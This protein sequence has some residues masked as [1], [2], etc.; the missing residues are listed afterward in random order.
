MSNYINFIFIEDSIHHTLYKTTDDGDS[1]SP[2]CLI[3]V[4]YPNIGE[5]I[6]TRSKQ[7]YIHRRP[8]ANKR[9]MRVL[10]ACLPYVDISV[11]KIVRLLKRDIDNRCEVFDMIS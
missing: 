6:C 9:P 8:L 3:S 5:T 2:R 7:M 10:H 1:P 11:C 4:T